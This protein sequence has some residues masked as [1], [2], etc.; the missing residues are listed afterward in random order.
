MKLD[1]KEIFNNKI[2]RMFLIVI[3]IIFLIIIAIGIYFGIKGRRIKS[4]ERLEEVILVAGKNYYHDNKNSLPSDIGKTASVDD[5][6]LSSSGY[7]KNLENI[8]PKGSQCSATVT[9]KN[10]N[11]NYVYY[12][13]LDCGENF[14]SQK[15]SDYIL[16]NSQI[17]TEGD[18][19]YENNGDYVYRGERPKNYIK[20]AGR[21]YRILSINSDKSISIISAHIIK[22]YEKPT[23]DDRYNSEKDS[24]FGINNYSLSRIKENLTNYINDNKYFKDSDRSKL[25]YQNLCVGSV[26]NADDVTRNVECYQVYENQI[27]GLLPVSNFK[28]ASLDK[29]CKYINSGSCQNYNYLSNYATSWW[30]LTPYSIDTYRAYL[31]EAL[32]IPG[33]ARCSTTAYPREVLK[34]TD[35]VAYSSGNGTKDA[36]FEIK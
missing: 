7:M 1:F 11:G 36:P 35:L 33:P 3:G 30:T 27:I 5:V 18:G 25:M 19:L 20:F 17:V 9:A 23:W 2:T 15:L 32:G 6:T 8:S 26:K 4:Y 16:S 10:V 14:K 21:K 34:L 28:Y 31:V 13:D 22:N 29:E 12:S 24:T